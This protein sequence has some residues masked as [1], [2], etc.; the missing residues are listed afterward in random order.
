VRA[1]PGWRVQSSP[2]PQEGG[3]AG[4]GPEAGAW[5]G[6]GSGQ[7]SQAVVPPRAGRH[8]AER[9]EAACRDVRHDARRAADRRP[10]VLKSAARLQAEFPEAAR[11]GVRR[12]SRGASHLRAESRFAASLPVVSRGVPP[13]A[14]AVERT[15]SPALRLEA[16]EAVVLAGPHGA[17]AVVAALHEAVVAALRE[18]V[19]AVVVGP[20]AAA[21]P[22]AGGLQVE[23]V[24]APALMV[25]A[26]LPAWQRAAQQAEPVSPAAARPSGV[27]S[28]DP[29]LPWPALRQQVHF[30]RATRRLRFASP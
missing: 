10:E 25:V 27:A 2:A 30:A 26:E 24:R 14:A 22:Q 6:Q 19:V 23:V 9:P 18:A 21:A 28:V 11:R 3:S 17:P 29:V 1:V 4:C 12:G 7:P 15:A 8:A 16:E 5:P 20:H 13:Q